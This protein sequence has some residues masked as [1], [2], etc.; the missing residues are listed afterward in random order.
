MAGIDLTGSL[1]QGV[2]TTTGSVST[3]KTDKETTSGS[4]M[5]KDAFLQ[6]LVAEMKYQ[7]PLQPTSNT[8]YIAQFAQFS[9]V[10]NLQN[11]ADNMDLT[12]AQGLVGET[13]VMASENAQ[14]DTEYVTGVVDSVTFEGGKAYLHI[15]GQ[16]YSIDDLEE[17]VNSEY[18]E[19]QDLITQL[20]EGIAN[21]PSIENLTVSDQDALQNLLSLYNGMNSYQQ[22]FVD[23][24]TEQTLEDYAAKMTQLL[25]SIQ[26]I[27]DSAQAAVDSGAAT[28]GTEDTSDTEETSE[29]E[30]AAG[31]ETTT[32]ETTG[33]DTSSGTEETT[34]TET[35]SGT[36]ETA[37]TETSSG[38]EETTGTETASGTEGTAGTESASGTEETD[39]SAVLGA[40]VGD[41]ESAD[42]SSG[43]GEGEESSSTIPEDAI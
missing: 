31:T 22:G 42:E 1:I 21:L 24:T 26:D 20:T 14:G 23:S 4:S 15:D 41:E 37:G 39:E 36:E 5:D 7:D 3:R 19:A 32:G 33:T 18:V 25:S 27:L 29:T 40:L 8:E 35:S 30:S 17:V 2:D 6:L 34:G 9:Q 10:E 38:T 28:E 12:R 11:M 13:V 43:E 16:S